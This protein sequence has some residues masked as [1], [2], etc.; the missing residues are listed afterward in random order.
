MTLP[1]HNRVYATLA[2][3]WMGVIYFLSSRPAGDYPPLFY[4][5]DKLV[6]VVVY[7]VLGLLVAAALG[8]ARA[9]S[10][11]PRVLLVTVIVAAYGVLDEFH[12]SFVP[13]REPSIGDV[14][15]DATGGFVAAM[16]FNRIRVGLTGPARVKAS[17]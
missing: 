16:F 8:R 12:Q 13:G 7:A 5:A 6:H 2:I 9:A 4:G 3:V 15:A 17:K 10:P 1:V 11:W 14:I